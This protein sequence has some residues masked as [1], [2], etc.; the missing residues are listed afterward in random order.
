[1]WHVSLTLTLQASGDSLCHSTSFRAAVLAVSPLLSFSNPANTHLL[2]QTSPLHTAIQP[3]H[4]YSAKHTAWQYHLASATYYWLSAAH[5]TPPPDSEGGLCL[6]MQCW[7]GAHEP[8]P[9]SCRPTLTICNL[10]VLEPA[11]T[12]LPRCWPPLLSPQFAKAH[13]L[14]CVS[15]MIRPGYRLVPH[16]PWHSPTNWFS[17]LPLVL[18]QCC[19]PL[20]LVTF[21]S[22]TNA[23]FMI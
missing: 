19:F 17:F 14:F 2:Y 15:R 4:L 16:P 13:H 22:T 3:M 11:F 21:S 18:S 5:A 12:C 10:N 23:H 7:P 6:C 1:M 8:Y 20:S 9:L